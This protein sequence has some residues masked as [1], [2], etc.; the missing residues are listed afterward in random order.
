MTFENPAAPPPKFIEVNEDIF[1]G[2]YTFEMVMKI[3][4]MGL[5]LN[6]NAYLRDAWGLLDFL[7]VMSAYLTKYLES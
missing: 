1:L 7:I 3:L 2:L 6:K 4:G 5:I